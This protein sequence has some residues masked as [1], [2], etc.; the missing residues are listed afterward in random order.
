MCVSDCQGEVAPQWLQVP[1]FS[2]EETERHTVVGQ[3]GS[4]G[5]GVQGLFVISGVTNNQTTS[6]LM[7]SALCGLYMWDL[8]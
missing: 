5:V 4:C 7:I 8:R 6:T 3:T 1:G 2:F